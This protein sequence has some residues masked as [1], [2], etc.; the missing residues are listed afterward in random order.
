MGVVNMAVVTYSLVLLEQLP[1][2]PIISQ[3]SAVN[4]DN[5]FDR[6]AGSQIERAADNK[7]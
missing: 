5:P 1:R 3:V 2:N 4:D 6:W 7:R